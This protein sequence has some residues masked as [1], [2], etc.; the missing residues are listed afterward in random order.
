MYPPVPNRPASTP[1]AAQCSGVDP[2][3]AGVHGRN[4]SSPSINAKQAS[5]E[6]A[7]AAQ[8]RAVR[9][10]LSVS[11][12][13]HLFPPT[14]YRFRTSSGLENLSRHYIQG[15]STRLSNF[16][17]KKQSNLQVLSTLRGVGLEF[18]A[19][20][21]KCKRLFPRAIFRWMILTQGH[22]ITHA[23]ARAVAS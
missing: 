4:P 9:P 6:P 3:A 17:L 15:L 21:H 14:I 20:H 7:P 10:R 22:A 11:Q 5:T 19:K 1:V 23:I 18:F 8:N 12:Q 13:S 2:S 16:I